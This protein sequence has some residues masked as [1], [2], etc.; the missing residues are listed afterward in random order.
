VSP[1]R[2]LFISIND[3]QKSQGTG[4]VAAYSQSSL[5]N[6]IM[7]RINCAA[8]MDSTKVFKCASDVGLSNQLNRTRQYFGP[9]NI[10]RLHIQV[11]DEYGRHVSLNHMD[12]SLTL[13]FDQLY[14]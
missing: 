3:G 11:L 2:Y 10:S 1:P 12:W 14:D 13:V 6:N 5:D 8:T 9:V 7:T 4:F